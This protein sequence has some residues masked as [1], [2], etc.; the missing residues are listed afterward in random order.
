MIIAEVADHGEL[1]SVDIAAGR[2]I[3]GKVD[4]FGRGEPCIAASMLGG[5]G[6]DAGDQVSPSRR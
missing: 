2:E 1:G 5:A 3:V 4:T 6:Q